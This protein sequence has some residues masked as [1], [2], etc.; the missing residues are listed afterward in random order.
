V[1]RQRLAIV[2]ATVAL[3]AAVVGVGVRAQSAPGSFTI[4]VVNGYEVA[5]NEVLV[6]FQ[7]GRP[8]P[9]VSVGAALDMD[10]HDPVASEWHRI[11]SA[12]LDVQTMMRMLSARGDVAAF[13]PNYVLHAVMTPNDPSFSL[14]WG[15]NNTTSPGKDIHAVAAW[16]ISQGAR[17]NT[18]VGVVDTGILYTH[19]DL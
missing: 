15:L 9:L 4:D 19:P 7:S 13:Q 12:S 14:L 5:A 8:V 17:G 6:K 2:C 10:R 11:H 16:D 1:F 18:V 3:G